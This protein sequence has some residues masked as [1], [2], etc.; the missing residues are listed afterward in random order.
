M[1]PARKVSGKWLLV[2]SAGAII[3]SL[4]FI[5]LAYVAL[6]PASNGT[7]FGTLFV[8]AGGYSNATGYATASYNATLTAQNGNGS[9]LFTFV[10]GTD[11]VKVPLLT[12]HN[13]TI[14]TNQVSM[15]TGGQS[16][17]L[18]WEDNDTVWAH[19]YDSNYISSW[20]PSAP[21]YEH[22]GQISPSIFGLPA[23][24]YVEFR[25]AAQRGAS[26]VGF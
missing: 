26:A 3:V 20:G 9:V 25:F 14:S 23:G 5:G 8:N 21:A 18:P 11:L 7:L 6:S 17:V 13:Y 2:L 1:V 10:S 24:D 12:I 4:A 19:L 15:V 22:R 16:V